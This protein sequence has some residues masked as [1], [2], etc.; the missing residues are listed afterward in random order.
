MPN[1]LQ[2]S[3]RD[4]I[5]YN[6]LTAPLY[7]S[8]FCRR[9]LRTGEPEL[10]ALEQL[11]PDGRVALD[12]G[13]NKGVFSYLLA[14]QGLDV[15]AFEPIPMF[16]E[17]VRRTAPHNLQCHNIA[18]SNVDGEADFHLPVKNGRIYNQTATL[19]TIGDDA[20][21]ITIKVQTSRLDSLL[22][23]N[24]GFIKID[25]EGF[26]K[27][28]LEGAV[29]TISRDRPVMLIEI[30]ESH[31]GEDLWTSLKF[32]E[33]LGY[34]THGYHEN[35]VQPLEAFFDIEKHHRNF[36]GGRYYNNFIFLPI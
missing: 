31:T 22:M 3:L 12:V 4:K 19:R 29:E 21:H 35:K 23:N 34:T 6:P 17:R 27:Q 15:H 18:L 20:E 25:A 26:E 8:Y 28:I 16:Y 1:T 36:A 5:K 10:Q 9:A 14:R 30:E 13:S 7:R 33:S 11:A 24:I 32:V 2:I